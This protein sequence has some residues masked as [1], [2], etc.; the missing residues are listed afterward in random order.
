MDINA[1]PAFLSFEG[2]RYSR[3]GKLGKRFDD[4][5]ECA[6]YSCHEPGRELRAWT[7]GKGDTWRD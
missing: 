7:D 4:G 1:F 3:T 6:E 5:R 2:R